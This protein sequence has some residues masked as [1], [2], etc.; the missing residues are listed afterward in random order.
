MVPSSCFASLLQAPI[1]QFLALSLLL[2]FV[3]IFSFLHH[4]LF[5]QVG[6]LLSPS[7]LSLLMPVT[8]KM[9]QNKFASSTQTIFQNQPVSILL[10]ASSR[11]RI[12]RICFLSAFFILSKYSFHLSCHSCSQHRDQVATSSLEKMYRNLKHCHSDAIPGAY[13]QEQEEVL[14]ECL[15][16][17][18]FSSSIVICLPTYVFS[19]SVLCC[20]VLSD[21]AVHQH[22]INYHQTTNKAINLTL[23]ITKQLDKTL[24]QERTN[25]FLYLP[26]CHSHIVCLRH[27]SVYR[28][29]LFFPIL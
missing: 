7:S 5:T 21:T 19:L 10:R 25:Q 29:C 23:N 26:N 2:L 15:V 16:S 11:V 28:M 14:F 27:S 13:R 6:S 18:L 3:S 12:F 20:S 22:N 17:C 1:C 8:T 24:L 4:Y 9:N